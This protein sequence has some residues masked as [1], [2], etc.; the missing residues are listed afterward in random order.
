[1]RKTPGLEIPFPCSCLLPGHSVTQF[2]L[3]LPQQDG[4]EGLQPVY[5]TPSF[6]LRG[7]ALT[8]PL[9][10][11]GSLLLLPKHANAVQQWASRHD[12]REQ[13]YILQKHQE[14]AHYFTQFF[15]FFVKFKKL[16]F[17]YR[18]VVKKLKSW[19]QYFINILRFNLLLSVNVTWQKSCQYQ[20]FDDISNLWDVIW[21]VF[22]LIWAILFLC[23][24]F[25]KV[26]VNFKYLQKCFYSV[27]PTNSRSIITSFP[28]GWEE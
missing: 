27:W 21:F 25:R 10:Q 5:H 22:S 16:A 4:G 13:Q 24:T 18:I 19:N 8:L 7:W 12:W 20:C 1:M 17:Q 15:N 3:P 11:R 23:P 9:L 2:F 14:N 28:K 26:G 6:L